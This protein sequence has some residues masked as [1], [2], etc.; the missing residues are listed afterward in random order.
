[1]KAR[2]PDDG[3][4]YIAAGFVFSSSYLQRNYSSVI[5]S[6][7]VGV[8]AGRLKQAEGDV[9]GSLHEFEQGIHKAPDLEVY[10]KYIMALVNNTQYEDAAIML[11]QSQT[12]ESLYARFAAERLTENSPPKELLAT[13]RW[14]TIF[15]H[16]N[17][18]VYPHYSEEFVWALAHLSDGNLKAADDAVQEAYKLLPVKKEVLKKHYEEMKKILLKGKKNNQKPK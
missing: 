17:T 12:K 15:L 16:P 7:N 3:D 11:E 5:L 6:I 8:A 14:M 9:A 13:K 10:T 1:M 4:T 2:Y 18:R